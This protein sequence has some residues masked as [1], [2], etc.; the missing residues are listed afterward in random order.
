MAAPEAAR[1]VLLGGLVSAGKT[2]YLAALWYA[3]RRTHGKAQ[4]S[5]SKL[6]PNVEFL[7]LLME[8]WISCHEADHTSAGSRSDIVLELAVAG[9]PPFE[10]ALPDY[11]GEFVRD[12]W[13]RRRWPAD[14]IQY[15]RGARAVLLL[16]HPGFVVPRVTVEEYGRFAAALE[17]GEPDPARKPTAFDAGAVPSQTMLVE[18]LQ[19]VRSRADTKLLPVAVLV[20]AWDEVAIQKKTPS[21]W[22]ASNLPLLH[23]F[24]ISN[25]ATL[26]STVFGVSAQGSDWAA[27][28]EGALGT[29]AAERA[30][31][32][33]ADGR[34]AP[35]ITVPLAWAISAS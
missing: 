31:V 22:L 33:D 2:S 15:I 29:L 1:T 26:P 24:L 28:R 9:S 20:S 11:S 27:G 18:F 17:A 3:L 4:V 6:P 10:L 34:P 8:A 13:I 12:A 35:D 30:Y 21:E 7:N 5:L 14:M 16:V 19:F 25:A 23:Q 32:V